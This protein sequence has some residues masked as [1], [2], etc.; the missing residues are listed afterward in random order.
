VVYSFGFSNGEHPRAWTLGKPKFT[1]SVSPFMRGNLATWP[2]AP[3]TSVIRGLSSPNC[4]TNWRILRD[5]RV[6][7]LC[8]RKRS[9]ARF[10]FPEVQNGE[11]V[12]ELEGEKWQRP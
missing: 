9:G 11:P 3:I 8:T 6:L 4:S 5:A 12:T 10:T 7:G 2:H 1:H